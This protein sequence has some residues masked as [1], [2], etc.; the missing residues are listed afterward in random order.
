MEYYTR[1]MQLE[2]LIVLPSENAPKLITNKTRKGQTKMKVFLP[3]ES[4]YCKYPSQSSRQDIFIELDCEGEG[5]L[6]AD[7]NALIGTA[8]P[9]EVWHGHTQRWEIPLLTE[10]ALEELFEKIEPLAKRVVAGYESVWDGNNHVAHFDEDATEAIKEIDRLTSEDNFTEDETLV[11]WN[12]HDWLTANGSNSAEEL[13]IHIS[14][15]E[16]EIETLAEK[17]EAEFKDEVPNGV[18]DGTMKEAIEQII[19]ELKEESEE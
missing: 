13:K 12:A 2:Q 16:D 18:T 3:D 19:E 10:N 8:V 5:R 14:M 17:Y 11:E 6:T 7:W 15:T 9:P 4:L 1:V